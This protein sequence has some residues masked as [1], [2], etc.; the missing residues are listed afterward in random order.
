MSRYRLKNDL[1]VGVQLRSGFGTRLPPYFRNIGKR[2]VK[3]PKLYFCDTGLAAFLLGIE[4]EKQIARDPL[5][6]N[7]FENLAVAE[8][9]KHRFHHG[10]KS[11]LYFYRD[12]KGNEV[13]LLRVQGSTFFPIEIKA[14][15]TITRDYFKGLK[16]FLGVFPDQ[17]PHGGGLVYGGEE[18]QQ[19]SDVTVVPLTRIRSLFNDPRGR[20][21]GDGVEILRFQATRA[22]RPSS[23]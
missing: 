11:N 14:G 10:Q 16:H 8:A 2:L 12:S 20:T 17:T 4:N 13:D 21:Q 23:S 15:M 1:S 3:S 6:G 18:A 22:Y 5:R 19:R 9:L 7:L